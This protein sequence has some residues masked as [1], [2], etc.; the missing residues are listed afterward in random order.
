MFGTL[1][2]LL[3]LVARVRWFIPRQGHSL[4]FFISLL[5]ILVC[6]HQSIY[7]HYRDLKAADRRARFKAFVSAL[8]SLPD[9]GE[10]SMPATLLARLL[11]TIYLTEA[12]PR[13]GVEAL[14][15]GPNHGYINHQHFSYGDS[16]QS[17]IR[18]GMKTGH[19][20]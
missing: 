13:N 2:Q 15:G 14:G 19:L 18:P 20:P 11:R 17:I 12:V 9:S 10:I 8:A 6:S 4:R 1:K 16:L 7:R 3:M 5:N